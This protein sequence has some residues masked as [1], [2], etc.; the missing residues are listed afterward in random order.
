M[1]VLADAALDLGSGGDAGAIT[2][3]LTAFSNFL[4]HGAEKIATAEAGIAGAFLAF[5][6]LRFAVEVGFGGSA[7]RGLVMLVVSVAWYQVATHSVAV[8]QSFMAWVGSFGAYMSGGTLEGNI[9]NNP[10]LFIDLGLH[11]FNSIMQHAIQFNFLVSAV[12][13][14]VYT[15]LGFFVE[16]CFLAMAVIVV[17]IVIQATLRMMLGLAFVPFVVLDEFRFLATKGLGMIIDAAVSLGAASMALGV[18]YGYLMN[19]K[20]ADDP[21]VRDCVRYVIIASGCGVI[22]GGA[23]AVKSGAS[24]VIEKYQEMRGTK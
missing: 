15:V 22:S 18:S 7:P 4:A 2:G 8:A 5:Q 21:T 20:F 13:V 6:F 23:A 9:M 19:I 17:F 12:A 3:L 1:I 10:S 11:A 14:I 24:F 16:L